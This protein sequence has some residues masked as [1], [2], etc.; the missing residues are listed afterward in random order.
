MKARH[1][2][3]KGFTL[4]ELMV[5]LLIIGILAA[6]AIPTLKGR[7]EA[8]KWTEGRAGCGSIATALRAYAAERKETGTYPPP[9]LFTLGF[10]DSDLN[11][12]YFTIANYSIPACTWTDGANPE[13]AFTIRCNNTGTGITVPTAIELDEAGN[14]TE[15][16]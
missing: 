14:W 13:L 15:I 10:Q 6:V 5:V 2:S 12:T 9:S 8:A 1:S 4:I 16:P 11:G 3:E 7:V